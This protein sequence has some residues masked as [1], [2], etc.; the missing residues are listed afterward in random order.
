[1]LKWTIPEG[2]TSFHVTLWRAEAADAFANS[3]PAPA[4][5]DPI[6]VLISLDGTQAVD[7]ILRNSTQAENWTIPV[8][9]AHSLSIMMEEVY[10]AFAVYLGDPGFSTKSVSSAA[11]RHVLRAGE[12]FANLGAGLRQ[13][14]LFDFHPGEMVPIQAEFG[15]SAR[16]A[17]IRLRVNP[18]VGQGAR[19]FLLQIPL[20]SEGS[21][22][23]GMGQW[24]VPRIYG[25]A[26]VTLTASMN[27]RQVYSA[28]AQV[29]LTKSPDPSSAS[30]RSNFGIH[31]STN[32]SLF[33]TDEGASL[34]GSKWAR[35]F[36]DWAVVESKQGQYDWHYIDYVV[37]SYSAQHLSLLGVMGELPPAWMNDPATQMKPAYARFVSAALEHFKGRIDH[38][39]VYNE[40][41]SKFYTDRG[42]RHEAQPTSDVDL[43]RQELTQITRFS[44]GLVRICCAPGGSDFLN[45]EKR[46][47]DA[48][49]LSMID[50]VEMHVYQTGPPEKS[51][52]GMNYVEMAQNLA[53]LT[54]KYG[55]TKQVWTTESNWLIGPAGTLP[56]TAPQV[57]EH[58]Q[59]QY[60]VR[61]SL[62]SLAM[63]DPYF[64]H[65]PFFFPWHRV[66]LVDSL[67]S[68]SQ[69]TSLM[70]A[71][72]NG[73]FLNIG[74]HIYG[75]TATAP[76]GTVTALWTDLEK[77]ASVHVSGIAHMRVED[78]Y[79]NLLSST[80]TI[81]LSGS[82]VYMI[83]QSAPSVTPAFSIG[84]PS[85]RLIPAVTA[86][87]PISGTH[88][89]SMHN[90]TVHITSPAT[91]YAAQLKSGV[92]SVAPN[93][94]YEL[95][96]SLDMHQGGIDVQIQDS[97]NNKVLK[98]DFIYTV[99]GSDRY[100]PTIRIK[101]GNTSHLQ[102]VLTDAN[103][104]KAAVSDFE[105]VNVRLSECQ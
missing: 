29:A 90:G 53:K 89:Q 67:A 39:D 12:A 46:L 44:P 80:D 17:D 52:F 21:R 28:T 54:S 7:T 84:S 11:V 16:M 19:D 48:G 30:S 10:G 64:I 91:T 68:Y 26:Q 78:M 104:H 58:E 1:M 36:V 61:A 49:L 6:R 18:I 92:F 8:N 103:P 100:N 85:Q 63:H 88:L 40:I 77:P 72:Q 66:V 79:G 57:T 27:G 56:V 93:S 96:L 81:Q 14:A 33:L 83:G 47:F 23:I 101:T 105:L 71:A 102:V 65:S 59:S 15:G 43:L 41:D 34:W 31:L 99:T 2:A 62:L 51:D 5:G 76:A 4:G 42:F 98:N 32:G 70:V 82:P 86:W 95:E 60:L 73:T 9:N 69:L 13:A 50:A 35:F 3:H 38:W 37:N 75:V 24:Q 87:Q 55:T 74:P 25:P 20:R 22:S 94:C 97:D 45:Y